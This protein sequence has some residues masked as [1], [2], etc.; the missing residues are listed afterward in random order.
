[1]TSRSCLL[2]FL[3]VLSFNAVAVTE[4]DVKAEVSYRDQIVIQA[5]QFVEKTANAIATPFLSER[6]VECLAKNIFY[7]SGG[8]PL[9]GKVAVGMVTINRANDPA[10]PN[11]ICNVVKQKTMLTATK[12]ETVTEKVPTGLF[13]TT[14]QVTRQRVVQVSRAV[15]QFSWVC[16]KMN[17]IKEDDPRWIESKAVAEG[18]ARGEYDEYQSKYANAKYFHAVYVKPGWKLKRVARTGNHIFYE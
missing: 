18:L 17:R 1:M 9:E 11:G 13:A 4:A 15:C 6:D 8:E 5:E 12:T 14:K 3:A 16:S 10:F 2:S 7:E